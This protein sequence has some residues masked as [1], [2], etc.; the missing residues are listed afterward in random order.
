MKL[1]LVF[2][3]FVAAAAASRGKPRLARPGPADNRVA[4]QPASQPQR[5]PPQ[6]QNPQGQNLQG[7]APRGQN[8]QGQNLQG[9]NIQGQN[10]QGQ[11]LPG[12]SHQE[13]NSPASNNRVPTQAQPMVTTA[14]SVPAVAAGSK[15][16]QVAASSVS[17]VR[18]VNAPAT[19]PDANP[20]RPIWFLAGTTAKTNDGDWRERSVELLKGYD[21]DL[22]NPTRNDW[23]P[24]WKNSLSDANFRTQV[25]WEHRNMERAET[26]VVFLH[27][28]TRAEISLMELGLHTKDA[29]KTILVYADPE[30]ALRGNVEALAE[31]YKKHNIRLF[32]SE[33][34]LHQAMLEH[35]K[36]VT[37]KQTTS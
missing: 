6:G 35:A 28:Q 1:S 24:D 12:Q 27:R 20:A 4:G 22:Y 19:V 36:K 37:G 17:G 9:Q 7:Q 32:Q 30:Y 8:L 29:S 23:G 18:V 21:L 34:Q 16:P 10:P 25:N 14:S 11:A 31:N 3:L 15:G 26:I 13:Q 33:R 2:T 5:Q